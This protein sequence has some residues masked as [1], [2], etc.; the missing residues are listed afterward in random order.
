SPRLPDYRSLP[1]EQQLC[2]AHLYRAGRD[3][4]YNANLPPSQLPFVTEWYEGFSSIYQDLKRY[5]AQPVDA[6]VRALNKDELWTKLQTLSASPVPQAG[7]PAKLA[8][9]KA[10]IARAGPARL[11]T[12]L[13]ADTPADNNRVERDLRQLVLKR[14]RAYGSKSEPGASALA[15]V[16]SVC[17]TAWRTNPSGYFAALAA[18]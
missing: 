15:T 8:R 7:Q 18:L 10:Q 6:A 11:F 9:L 2:W 13:T 14:K 4:R 17:T 3:L 1:G 5:L 12:C 16:L